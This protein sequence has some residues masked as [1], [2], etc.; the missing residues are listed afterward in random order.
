MASPSPS[1]LVWVIG[2]TPHGRWIAPIMRAAVRA[3][4]PDAKHM[5]ST[6][7]GDESLAHELMEAAI[8]QVKEELADLSPVDVE[9]AQ[10]MLVRAYRNAVRRERRARSKL[11]LEGTSDD[12]EFLL[13]PVAPA[14][15]AI[16]AEHDLATLLRDTPPELQ[17]ALMMRYGARSRWD[18]VAEEVQTSQESIRIRCRRELARIRKRLGIQVRP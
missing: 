7:L 10:T 15:D 11:T 12:V 8:Q 5:A 16:H 2:F 4:W 18:E 14:A 1:D 9:E 3:E 17:R 13:S 6:L